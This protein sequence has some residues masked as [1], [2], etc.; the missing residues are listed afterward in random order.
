VLFLCRAPFLRCFTLEKRALLQEDAERVP[1]EGKYQGKS[2]KLR[3]RKMPTGEL[4]PF[5][6]V[7]FEWR[8]RRYNQSTGTSAFERR[9]VS[10]SR[11][12]RL[13]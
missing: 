7:D 1:I 10:P 11:R 13:Q 6:Y 4:S 8:R 12:L 5:L 3:R 2:Y 9:M